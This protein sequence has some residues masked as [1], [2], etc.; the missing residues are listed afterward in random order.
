M[1][2]F[3]KSALILFIGSVFFLHC[4]QDA[5][6]AQEVNRPKIGLVLGGGEGPG[7]RRI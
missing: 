4:Y 1:S 5:F 6:G 7:A 3:L 2:K